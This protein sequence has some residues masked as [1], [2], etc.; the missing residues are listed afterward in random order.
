M[1]IELTGQFVITRFNEDLLA[2]VLA[3]AQAALAARKAFLEKFTG[4]PVVIVD[5]DW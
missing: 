3:E 4:L 5:E 1:R 2:E